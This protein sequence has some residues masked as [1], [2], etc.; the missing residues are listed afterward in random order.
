MQGSARSDYNN[1]KKDHRMILIVAFVYSMSN[2]SFEDTYAYYVY[3]NNVE[4]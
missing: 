2:T 4:E 1:K 3:F